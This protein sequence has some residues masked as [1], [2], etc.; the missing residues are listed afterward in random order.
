MPPKVEKI[1][2]GQDEGK[3]KSIQVP[4]A[5]DTITRTCAQILAEAQPI[6]GGGFLSAEQRKRNMYK[7]PP[8][9]A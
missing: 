8:S 9:A 2:R 4:K 6:N 5:E 1:S 7:R 3:S